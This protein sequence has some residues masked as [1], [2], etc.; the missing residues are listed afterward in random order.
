MLCKRINSGK[1]LQDLRLGSLGILPAK[2]FQL[3]ITIIISNIKSLKKYIF[4]HLHAYFS[5][6]IVHEVGIQG[7]VYKEDRWK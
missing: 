7:S 1:L 5:V 3:Q 4:I 6:F 2:E